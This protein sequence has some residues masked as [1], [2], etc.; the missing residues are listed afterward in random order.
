MEGWREVV[1]VC[2]CGDGGCSVCKGVGLV[3]RGR[4]GSEALEVGSCG[5]ERLVVMGFGRSGFVG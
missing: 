2:C 4:M 1:G 3:G 5:T